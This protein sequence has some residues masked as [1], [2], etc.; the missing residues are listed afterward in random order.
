MRIKATVQHMKNIFPAL[1]GN[2]LRSRPRPSHILADTG[3]ETTM[4]SICRPEGV[5]SPRKSK[6]MSASSVCMCRFFLRASSEY[7]RASQLW[8]DTAKL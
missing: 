5:F 8:P 4:V 6:H 1:R 2:T 3:A 7:S